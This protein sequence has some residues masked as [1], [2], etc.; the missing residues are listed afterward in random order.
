MDARPPPPVLGVAYGAKPASQVRYFGPYLGGQQ[1]KRAI[2]GLN[3][4]LP[5]SCTDNRLSGS[6]RDIA[7]GRG[8]G[9]ADLSA[10]TG[11][12]TAI[13][14]REPAAVSRARGML[15]RLRDR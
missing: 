5:L 9:G 15:E 14:A 1:V 4:I 8:A 3:R 7:R 2:T 11:A 12:L 10:V 13:L 6:E